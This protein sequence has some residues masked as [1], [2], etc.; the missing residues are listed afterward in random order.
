MSDDEAPEEGEVRTDATSHLIEIEIPRA[1]E[2]HLFIPMPL[3]SRLQRICAQI[4]EE[5]SNKTS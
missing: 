2:I 3:D 1:K 5:P 4:L